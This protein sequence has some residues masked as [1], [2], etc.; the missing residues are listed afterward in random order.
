[1]QTT[2]LYMN[3]GICLKVLK[4]CFRSFKDLFQLGKLSDTCDYIFF[5]STRS[6]WET[7][8]TRIFSYINVFWVPR[9]VREITQK[10]VFCKEQRQLK[11]VVSLTHVGQNRVCFVHNYFR[12]VGGT[13]LQCFIYV[14]MCVCVCARSHARPFVYEIWTIS[15]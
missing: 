9:K 14:Y 4:I 6:L 10:G 12:L 15:C 5:D 7:E 11:H 8:W 3:T 2:A 13:L 1:M